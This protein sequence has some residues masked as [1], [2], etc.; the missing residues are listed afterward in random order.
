MSL[1]MWLLPYPAS[2][3]PTLGPVW[4]NTALSAAIV[5]SQIMWRMWPPPTAY[6]ATIATTGLGQRRICT[7]RSR[8]L[9]RAIPSL[10][11]Y[12][13]CPRTVWSP[14]LQN[15]RSPRGR[16]RGGMHGVWLWA[17][18]GVDAG[19]A[20]PVSTT[21]P[22]VESSRASSRQ[23]DISLTVRGVKAFLL[24]GRLMV[25]FAMPS[26]FSYRTSSSV[27]PW[28][29]HACQAGITRDTLPWTLA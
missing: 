15:A 12:P 14:P 21:A 16:Q 20:S 27:Q 7:C 5:R 1:A 18:G 6:P 3:D 10:P 24:W 29:A 9:R 8:T 19:R 11:T 4:P 17:H 23:R 13:P 28:T 22:M 2:N 26:A 25:I